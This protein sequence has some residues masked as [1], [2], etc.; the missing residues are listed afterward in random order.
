[1]SPEGKAPVPREPLR[2][3]L[4]T[5]T[6]GSPSTARRESS[7]HQHVKLTDKKAFGGVSNVSD[8]SSHHQYT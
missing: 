2:S 7:C 6:L 4:M 5:S 8:S 1:M 3:G